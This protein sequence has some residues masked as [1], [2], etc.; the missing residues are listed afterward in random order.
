MLVR[1]LKAAVIAATAVASVAVM[2]TPAQAT[3]YC[4]LGGGVYFC[5]Y[6]VTSYPLPNG[7]TQEFVVGTDRAV[8]TRWTNTN[9]QWSRWMSM[10]GKAYSKV[11][12]HDYETSDPWSFRAFYWD[13]IGEYWGSN[14]DHDGNWSKWTQYDTPLKG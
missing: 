12:V 7:T 11:Y 13:Q 9:G 4:S 3:N 1:K 5:D 6:G 2:A 10:G 8:W 14:R